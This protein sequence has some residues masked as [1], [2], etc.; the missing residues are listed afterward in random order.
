MFV[1]LHLW[2]WHELF[3]QGLW[4][5]QL[6]D[7]HISY[8]NRMLS[9]FCNF[10]FFITFD[11]LFWFYTS[12]PVHIFL[13]HTVFCCILCFL[14]HTM[15]IMFYFVYSVEMSKKSGLSLHKIPCFVLWC[16][17]VSWNSWWNLYLMKKNLIQAIRKR[18]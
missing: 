10:S 7:V 15:N 5:D 17:T 11:F 14:V 13:S 12:S 9:N 1:S 18:Q 2:I 8:I 4:S 16:L 6:N 3:I